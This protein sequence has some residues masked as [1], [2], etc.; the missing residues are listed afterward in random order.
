MRKRFSALMT[1]VQV[2]FRFL[3]AAI[4]VTTCGLLSSER[5]VLAVTGAPISQVA[6]RLAL[7]AA[8][9]GYFVPRRYWANAVLLV[10]FF[11]GLLGFSWLARRTVIPWFE[12][13]HPFRVRDYLFELITFTLCLAPLQLWHRRLEP[14][15]WPIRINRAQPKH[16]P[17]T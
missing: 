17:P 6:L 7:G 3:A 16:P 15:D 12:N 9:I 1:D 2:S 11:G 5:L 4:F 8:A 14:V 13:G 10:L